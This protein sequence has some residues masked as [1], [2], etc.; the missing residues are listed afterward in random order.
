MTELDRILEAA[1]E[2]RDK[3][4]DFALATVVGVRGSTYR[5]LGSRQLLG[6]DGASVGT[7]SGGCL[8]ADLHRAAREVMATGVPRLIEFDLTADDEAVWGWGIGC[9]GAT[10]LVVEP[11]AGVA[12]LIADLQAAPRPVV[13]VHHLDPDRIGLRRLFRASGGDDLPRSVV[14]AIEEGRNRVTEVEGGPAMVELVGA[15]HRLVV[16]GAGH[17]AVPLVRLAAE[18]G[19]ETVVVDDRRQFLTSDRFPEAARLVLTDPAALADAVELDG[20][21]SVVIMSH[22]YLRDLDYLAAALGQGVSY[23]G[24]LGPGDRLSRLL[25]DLSER[26]VRPR[27]HDLAVLHGPAGLDIGAEGPAEIAWSILS[28]ITAVHRRRAAGFLRDRKG[29]P[30]LREYDRRGSRPRPSGDER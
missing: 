24:V 18:L 3:G 9:N 6:A 13:V 10:R 11:A 4:L 30:E 1:V 8:D 28:E 27:P 7:V 26:D 22:N 25:G 23:I 5:G 17:D 16:C 14:E 20:S 15:A 21:A 2:W 29:P 12:A 19:Y